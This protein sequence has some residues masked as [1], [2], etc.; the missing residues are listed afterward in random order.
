MYEAEDECRESVMKGVTKLILAG[1]GGIGAE[2]VEGQL[3]EETQAKV[4]DIRRRIFNSTT[5]FSRK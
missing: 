1:R 2:N 3:G 4:K 5:S